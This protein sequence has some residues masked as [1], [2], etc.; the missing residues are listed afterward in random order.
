M[1]DLLASEEGTHLTNVPFDELWK[2][3]DAF[4][5]DLKFMLSHYP[6]IM[7][8]EGN[9]L[10]SYQ[11]RGASIFP[12]FGS[13]LEAQEVQGVIMLLEY[14]SSHSMAEGFNVDSTIQVLKQ[15]FGLEQ[16]ASP[17]KQPAFMHQFSA[18][19]DEILTSE[20]ARLLHECRNRRIVNVR[21]QSSRTSEERELEFHPWEFVQSEGRWYIT[22]YISHDL[23]GNYPVNSRSN[24]PGLVLKVSEVHAVEIIT[25]EELGERK[26]DSSFRLDRHT[27]QRRSAQPHLLRME[28]RIGIGGWDRLL[29]E[30][31]QKRDSQL[32]F[33]LKEKSLPYFKTSELYNYAK[34]DTALNDNDW[35]GFR[36]PVRPKMKKHSGLSVINR[37]TIG[38]L[39]SFG[40]Q[41]EVIEPIE[42][43]ERFKREYSEA[44]S[45]YSNCG[46]E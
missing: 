15:W 31:I 1:K 33:K 25:D 3:K 9:K 2:G 7:Q 41:L 16:E 46:K 45:Y 11:E 40:H 12:R 4:R 32:R 34:P 24:F 10:W 29:G 20:N 26:K 35:L 22:G 27:F 23:L 8:K 6:G 42:L 19:D 14:F 37:E 18:E 5:K 44:T 43:R 36:I 38:I 30:E 13:T 17:S 21:Y 28:N 39:R